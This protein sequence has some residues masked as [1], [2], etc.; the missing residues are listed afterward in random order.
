MR[1]AVNS[2][3]A[4]RWVVFCSA[5]ICGH[6]SILAQSTDGD[7]PS[8][9]G[10]NYF[11]LDELSAYLELESDYDHSRVRGDRRDPFRRGFTQ[12]NR[13]LRVEEKFGLRIDGSLLDPGLISFSGDFSFGLVQQRFHE[14]TRLGSDSDKDNGT[15]L[16]YDL[17]ANLFQGKAIS[18]S[19]Y[20]LRRDD[21][22]A[23]RFQPTLNEERTGFG[24]S[25]FFAHD[26]FPMELTYDY[27]ETDRDGNRDSRDDEHYTEST[28]HYGA[29]WII[30]ETHRAKLSYE[31]AETKQEFQGIALPFET[32]R[33]LFTIEH[34][35]TFGGRRQHSLRT[36]IHWQEESG[37]FARDFF[38]VGPQ[39]TLQ[40]TDNLQTLY[41]Y[42]FNR[43]RFEGLDIE[44]HRSDFQLVHQLYSNLTTTVD[45]FG[46]HEDVED[47]VKTTQYGASVDW[48]YNRRNPYGHLYANL[49]LAYDSERARGDDGTRVVLDEAAT[50]RDPVSILLRNRNVIPGSIVVTDSSGRR[51]LIAGL[52]F[53]VTRTGNATRL[54]RI[55]TGRIADGDTV[56]IDYR[57]R[58]PTTGE[59]DTVRVD[60]SVEQQ[61]KSGVTP[62]YRFS[63]RNQE[64]EFSTGFARFADRTNHHRLGVKYEANRYTLG[65]EYEVFDDS[66]EPY[67][68]FHGDGLWHIVRASEHTVDASARFSRFFF[69]GGFDRR[70]VNMLDVELDHRWRLGDR[71]ATFER[72]TFRWED[73][74]VDGMTKAW[75]ATAGVD[76]TIGAFTA[77]VSVEY[78]RLDLPDSI[79]DD[80]GIY[81]RVRRDIPNVLAK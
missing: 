58:T 25:W 22:I 66:I 78:D 5:T 7:R 44:T 67:D 61:F 81:V 64:D 43:E 4:W 9:G 79:E 33:D 38:E 57:Y 65:T 53:V 10:R 74:S 59:I 31:H 15:L 3:S 29:E 21:R 48:Q 42:Q 80:V 73:D 2:R 63:H 50:F 52:D 60:F 49:A 17:R 68:A 77:E 70:N 32:T 47:D 62:Y 28:L 18:G 39:L 75:D 41:K 76:Y 45:F 40:H 8:G 20:G 6:G 51:R 19:V 11:R 24:T 13:D 34:D 36:L 1:G 14:S 30:S 71:L 27:L 26:R 55:L 16:E 46:L 54:V 56:L 35:L 69:E 12:E 23:R 37:D 72:L